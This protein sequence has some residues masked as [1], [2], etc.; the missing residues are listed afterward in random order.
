MIAM[1]IGIV[2]VC[3]LLWLTVRLIIAREN[4]RFEKMSSEE[5]YKYQNEMRKKRFF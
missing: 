3:L 2:V 1:I 4:K 5:R